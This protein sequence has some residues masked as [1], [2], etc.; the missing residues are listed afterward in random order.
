MCSLLLGLYLGVEFLD[1]MVILCLTF[2]GTAGL[3]STVGAQF[4]I[5]TNK[6]EGIQFLH[7]LADTGYCLC[8][9]DGHPR[10]CEVVSPCGYY[11]FVTQTSKPN[12]IKKEALIMQMLAN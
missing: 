8:F 5:P 4:Y 6:V 7:T 3:F 9:K 2:W 11:V 10:G 1:H 12:R